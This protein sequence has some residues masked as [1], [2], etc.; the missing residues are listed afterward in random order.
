MAMAA[1]RGFASF[2]STCRSSMIFNLAGTQPMKINEKQWHHKHTIWV[3]SEL[4]ETWV[5]HQDL[6]VDGFTSSQ[7]HIFVS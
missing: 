7:L 5:K 1:W 6:R 2:I 4:V 3:I